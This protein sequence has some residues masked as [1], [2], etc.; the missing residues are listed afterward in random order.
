M[1]PIAQPLADRDIA[2]EILECTKQQLQ[3]GRLVSGIK[4]CQKSILKTKVNG[5]MVFNASTSPMDLITHI[6]ILC[7]DRQIPYVFVESKE[8]LN[9][10]TCVL[11]NISDDKEDVVKKLVE[12]IKTC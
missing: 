6:P 7:E 1:L 5:L 12:K 8:Y 4:E 3:D 9:G 11:L 2:N 10:F